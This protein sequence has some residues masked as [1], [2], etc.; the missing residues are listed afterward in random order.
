MGEGAKRTR[1]W[2]C[3]APDGVLA[4]DEEEDEVTLECY[5][6]AREEECLPYANAQV[7]SRNA[8]MPA[9]L[10]FVQFDPG[11]PQHQ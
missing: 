6:D 9:Q 10:I 4:E 7:G 2:G 3:E 8:V 11:I 1:T 5:Q